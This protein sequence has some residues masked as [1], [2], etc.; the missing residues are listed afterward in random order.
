[1][2]NNDKISLF[3]KKFSYAFI[4]LIVAISLFGV[5]FV[6]SLIRYLN[7]STGTSQAFLF[8]L[9]V[10][11][12]GPIWTDIILIFILP[13]IF[14]LLLK[15]ILPYSTLF[16]VKIHKMIYIFREKPEYGIT[17]QD[18]NL[19]ISKIMYRLLIASFL[20]IALSSIIVQTSTIQLF[21]T[22]NDNISNLSPSLRDLLSIDASYIA[23][24]FIVPLV[25]II[26]IP[27]WMLED[28]GLLAYRKFSD[29][30]K[31][32]E[33]IGVFKQF[34]G[35]IGYFVGILTLVGYVIIVI[36][37]INLISLGFRIE[38]PAIILLL[39]PFI[40]SGILTIPLYLYEKT[41]NKNVDKVRNYIQKKGYEEIIIPEFN[42][43]KKNNK[44]K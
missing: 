17:I 1:M 34:K 33:I 43:I 38:I 30:R 11:L 42:D 19:Y 24:L 8:D 40:L 35:F 12:P 36:K 16:Y 26:L 14:Y 32:P 41:Y 25:I 18:N 22:V 23:S 9:I 27:L 21:R 10:I 7:S 20:T 44:I 5:L 39:L 31:N 4:C 13:I 6:I 37:I 28:S 29:K 3:S 2:F 15:Y